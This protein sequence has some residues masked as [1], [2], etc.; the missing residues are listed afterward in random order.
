MN[1]ALMR[2]KC[3]SRAR[4]VS[5]L[6]LC[7]VLSGQ[8]VAQDESLTPTS[9]TSPGDGGVGD[10]SDTVLKDLKKYLLNLGGDLGYQLDQKPKPATSISSTL[11]EDTESAKGVESIQSFVQFEKSTIELLLGTMPIKVFGES[12]SESATTPPNSLL[13]AIF[14]QYAKYGQWLTQAGLDK[15][16]TIPTGA[17]IGFSVLPQIDQQIDLGGASPSSSSDSS[18]TMSSYLPDPISQLIA[19]KLYTPSSAYCTYRTNLP[20]VSPALKDNCANRYSEGIGFGVLG[21]VPSL[22][23]AHVF[24]MSAIRQI[25]SN[26]LIAPL[27]YSSAPVTPVNLNG[28]S[29]TVTSQAQEAENF[30]RYVSGSFLQ[31]KPLDPTVY[32]SLYTSAK[33][34]PTTP[35]SIAAQAQLT[36]YFVTLRTMSAQVSVAVGNLYAIASKRMPQTLPGGESPAKPTSEAMQEYLMA[37]KRLY[38]PGKSG[39][40]QQPSQWVEKINK[41]SSATVQKEIAILLAEMNYQLYQQRQQQERLLLTESVMTIELAGLLATQVNPPNLDEQQPGSTN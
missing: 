22:L 5:V 36:N 14:K 34:T 38:D 17:A 26:T 28:I 7:S 8:A 20:N 16:T 3:K 4:L 10:P 12:T 23:N 40:P 13:N 31:L 39:A 25:N 19:N 32:N 2:Q 37:T 30:I 33:S 41:A 9:L 6:L 29:G 21:D 15:T 35:A 24:D 18:S 11:L 1:K 27:V